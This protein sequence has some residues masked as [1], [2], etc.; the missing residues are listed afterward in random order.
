ERRRLVRFNDI[1]PGL[2]HAVIS[3][4]DKRFF[5]HSGF[6]PLRMMKAAWVD[7]RSGKKR[8]G[9]STLTMQLARSFWLEP[10]KRWKRK[11]EELIITLH[12]ER[13][14]TKQQIFEFY[15]NQVYLGRRESFSIGG[16]A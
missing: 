4:E 1:P 9:A 13:K 6:D 16:F 12:M 7:L 8:Q 5:A 3:V 11:I 2:V 14:L 10:E 15:A